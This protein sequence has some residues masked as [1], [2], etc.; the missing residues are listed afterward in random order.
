MDSTIEMTASARVEDQPI[1]EQITTAV[2][3]AE[4]VS[5][6][7]LSQPLYERI[8][9][10]ALDRLVQTKDVTVRFSYHGYEV[11][12]RGDGRVVVRDDPSVGG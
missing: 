1:V 2:A 12:V 9:P 5:P 6:V 10:D 7:E 4:G 11:E 8:D 3:D